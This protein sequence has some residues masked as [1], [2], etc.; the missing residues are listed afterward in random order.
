MYGGTASPNPDY[1]QEV[2]NVSGTVNV[3]VQNKNSFDKNNVV[4][5][6]NKI[7]NDSGTEVSDSTGGYTTMYIPVSS[8]NEY[9]ISGLSTSGAKRIYYFDENKTFISRSVA[10]TANYYTFTTPENCKYVDIQYYITGNDFSN[11]Q[12]EQG[13]TVTDY[14]EHEEQTV[15]LTLPAGMEMCKIGNYKDSFVRQEGKWYKNKVIGKYQFTGNENISKHTSGCFYFRENPYGNLDGIVRTPNYIV[16]THFKANSFNNVF[17]NNQLGITVATDNTSNPRIAYPDIET[18][19]DFKNFLQN[20]TVIMYFPINTPVLEEITDTILIGQLDNLA[21]LYSYKGTTIISSDDE[22]SPIFNVEYYKQTYTNEEIDN[23]LAEKQN[24]L[25]SG[26]N[27][28]TVNNQSILGSGNIEIQGGSSSG[29]EI[30]IGDE[31]DAPASTKL[32]IDENTVDFYSEVVN[33]LSGDETNKAPS[34]SA[35]NNALNNIETLDIYSTT[36]TRV[37]TWID[38]KP[39]YRKVIVQELTATAGQHFNLGI[40]NLDKIVWYGGIYYTEYNV[41]FPLPSN[42]VPGADSYMMGIQNIQ[43]NQDLYF[44]MGNNVKQAG[45]LYLRV[46]YT[47]TTDQGGAN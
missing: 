14:V 23:L 24:T 32:L 35:V 43:P 18:T 19:A 8:S 38:G 10:F 12:L 31:Q 1:P 44:N 9:T 6:N 11:W 17:V 22:I 42:A 47:K 40:S 3:K 4:Y 2:Q 5:V 13:S 16:C 15:I 7:L 20:N 29:N 45:T 30:Y 37:G 25:V 33:S 36:E 27:I 39:L 34:V 26:T 41:T 21:N 28:K 46:E